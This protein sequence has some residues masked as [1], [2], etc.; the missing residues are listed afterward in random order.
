MTTITCNCN[1]ENMIE[2]LTAHVILAVRETRKMMIAN[3]GINSYQCACVVT[4]KLILEHT[5]IERLDV[6]GF[7]SLVGAYANSD[8]FI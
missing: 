2:P 8:Y 3:P 4:D 5:L 1:T 6:Q 7:V